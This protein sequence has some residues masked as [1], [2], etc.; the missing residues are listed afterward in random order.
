MIYGRGDNVDEATFESNGSDVKDA[1]V[2]YMFFFL[3]SR[4]CG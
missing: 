1:S 4:E 2:L 3:K